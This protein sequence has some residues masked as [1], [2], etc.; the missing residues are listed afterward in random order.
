MRVPRRTFLP[1]R[2]R[3]VD[4]TFTISTPFSIKL[5]F[6]LANCIRFRFYCYQSRLTIVLEWANDIMPA[7]NS[8]FSQRQNLQS[9]KASRHTFSFC[10][11]ATVML[12]SMSSTPS[13]H[14]VRFFGSPHYS[15]LWSD[16]EHSGQS[17][18]GP[19]FQPPQGQRSDF[20]IPLS[21]YREVLLFKPVAK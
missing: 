14:H 20:P 21:Q 8:D 10:R 13:P 17:L 2:H 11:W 3:I 1:L 19:H 18:V 6:C 7:I 15:Q 16:H 4:F 12:Q 9:P 5:L